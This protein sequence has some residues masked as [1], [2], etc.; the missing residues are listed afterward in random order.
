MRKIEKIQTLDQQTST[1]KA[2]NEE[3]ASLAKKL[4]DQVTVLVSQSISQSVSQL[5]KFNEMEALRPVLKMLPP[6]GVQTPAGVTV[7]RQ[8]RLSAERESEQGHG[9]SD[10]PHSSREQPRQAGPEARL[11]HHLSS[12]AGR[13]TAPMNKSKTSFKLDLFQLSI[14]FN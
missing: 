14:A 8:Q 2:E 11:H 4:K 6:S 3:L 13:P 1:L 10:R 7:A 5:M 12:G 9:P